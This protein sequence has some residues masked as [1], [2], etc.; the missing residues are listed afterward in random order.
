MLDSEIYGLMIALGIL[1]A[2]FY[3]G[4]MCLFI[5]IDNIRLRRRCRGHEELRG[6]VRT[7]NLKGLLLILVEVLLVLCLFLVKEKFF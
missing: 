1:L 2:L 5:N 7:E 4:V 6:F 3:F